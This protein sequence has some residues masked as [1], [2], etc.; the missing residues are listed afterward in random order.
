MYK[1]MGASFLLREGNYEHRAPGIGALSICCR[2]RC[3]P[4]LPPCDFFWSSISCASCL[5][6][7]AHLV[8]APALKNMWQDILLRF[9]RPFRAASSKL[10]FLFVVPP[11]RNASK[12]WRSKSVKAQRPAKQPGGPYVSSPVWWQLACTGHSKCCKKLRF[13]S[14]PFKKY[15]KTCV[16]IPFQSSGDTGLPMAA[17][18]ARKWHSKSIEKH[19]VFFSFRLKVVISFAISWFF[20]VQPAIHIPS[21]SFFWRTSAAECKQ[22]CPCRFSVPCPI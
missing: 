8:S 16:F 9:I 3:G 12:K 4:G 18:F 21:C 5:P 19:C 2:R 15:R 1:Q 6:K 20:E 13:Y 22:K 14:L 11:Q 10:P 17:Q 7:S